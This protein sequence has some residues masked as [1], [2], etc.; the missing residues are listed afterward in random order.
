MQCVTCKKID[1]YRPWEGLVPV[2]G[3]QVMSHGMRCGSCGEIVFNADQV[4]AQERAA[5]RALV[6]RG[7]R[8]GNELRFVRKL[9]GLTAAE[10]SEILDVRPETVSRWERGEVEIPR[11]VAFTIGQ[12]YEHPRAARQRLDALARKPV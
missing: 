11:P 9:A 3:I 7:V 12:L 1:S 5:A 10:L 4:R 2:M 8:A 6:T